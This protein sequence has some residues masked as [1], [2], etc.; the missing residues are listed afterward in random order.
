MWVVNNNGASTSVNN[1][2]MCRAKNAHP[3]TSSIKRF[4]S[5]P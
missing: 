2:Q 4:S 1:Q 5:N 3:S